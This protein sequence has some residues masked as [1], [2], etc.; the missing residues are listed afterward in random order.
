MV[1]PRTTPSFKIVVPGDHGGKRELTPAQASPGS[2]CAGPYKSRDRYRG[3]ICEGITLDHENGF[4]GVPESVDHYTRGA[5][6]N[7]LGEGIPAREPA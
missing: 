6:F 3:K 2:F 1:K 7:K 5:L 4:S